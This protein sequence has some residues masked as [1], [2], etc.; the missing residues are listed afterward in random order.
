MEIETKKVLKIE[1]ACPN[2]YLNTRGHLTICLWSGLLVGLVVA[3]V[4][5]SI[6]F[7]PTGRKL[8]DPLPIALAFN[9]LLRGI[10]YFNWARF[11]TAIGV[12]VGIGVLSWF[13]GKYI[14]HQSGVRLM[15][16]EV[17]RVSNVAVIASVVPVLLKE[18][19]ALQVFLWYG[20]ATM[21]SL[22][23]ARMVAQFLHQT[24]P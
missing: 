17:R 5:N 24:F 9:S 8:N 2:G 3:F 21:I 20:I 6:G 16:D 10:V 23:I 14:S 18:V 13:L 11:F 22:T 12:S 4:I 19:D 1:T 7:L 15:S